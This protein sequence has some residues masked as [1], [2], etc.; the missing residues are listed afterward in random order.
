MSTSPRLRKVGLSL[1]EFLSTGGIDD[2][3][4]LEDI[5]GRIE[6]KVS[7]Q[8]K[9]SMLKAEFL[10]AIDAVARP[11]PLSAGPSPSCDARSAGGR[12]SP[13]WCSS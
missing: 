3:P 10:R 2:R 12:S 9:H 7:P 6:A 11:A 8:L 4:Y 1:D 13:T 5:D